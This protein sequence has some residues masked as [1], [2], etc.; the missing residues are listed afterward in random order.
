MTN[1]DVQPASLRFDEAEGFAEN[2]KLFLVHV[3]EVDVEMATIL[4]DNWDA[5]VVIVREGDRDSKARGELNAKVASALDALVA[6]P[7]EPKGGA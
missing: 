3:E 1:Q 7:N 2:C 4:Q 6:K 5:L